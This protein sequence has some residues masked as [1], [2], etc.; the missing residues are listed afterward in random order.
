MLSCFGKNSYYQQS[1]HNGNRCSSYPKSSPMNCSY[2]DV[3]ESLA[4][5]FAVFFK[6]RPCIETD[7]NRSQVSWHWENDEKPMEF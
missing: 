2:I 4:L 1:S 5:V 6:D 7:A 3:V